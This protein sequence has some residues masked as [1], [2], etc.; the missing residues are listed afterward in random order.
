MTDPFMSDICCEGRTSTRLV[1][2]TSGVT[3]H[4]SLSVPFY[5]SPSLITQLLHVARRCAC[6][7]VNVHNLLCFIRE[8]YVTRR[9]PS[10]KRS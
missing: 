1:D 10:L 4:S 6:D 7:T 2:P 9:A 3:T 8:Q 5:R